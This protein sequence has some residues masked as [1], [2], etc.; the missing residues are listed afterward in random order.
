MNPK[1]LGQEKIG[2]LLAQQSAP[3]VIGMLVMS[4]YNFVDTI[5]IGRGVGTE[6]I[7]ALSIVF[8][9]QM[10]IGA[11]AMTMGIGAASVISRKLGKKKYGYVA[12]TFGTFQTVNILIA[13]IFAVLGLFLVK[14]LLVF[15]GA[16]PE[17]MTYASQ[18]FSILLIGIVFLCFNM[19]NNS[20]IRSVG[21]A[22]T[23]MI[24]MTVS[25]IIN[26]ILDPIMIFGLDMGMAGAA[27]A[28]VISRAVGSTIVLKYYFG[29]HNLIKTKISDYKI[30]FARFKEIFLVGVPS[31]ARQVAASGVVILINN[32]LGIYGG[33]LAIAAYGIINRALM[34]FFMPMF[35]VVQGM[36]PILGYNYGAG[37][38]TRV[39]E[40]TLLSI[41]VLTI[42]CIAIFAISMIFP[43][44]L[45]NLFSTDQELLKMAIPA[46]RI[47]VMMFPLIGFQIVASGFYQAL[48]KVRPA[49][50]FAI[51]RQVL[52]LL[53]M[54]L[55]IPRIFGLNGVWYSFP[56][57]DFLAAVVI[58]FVFRRDLKRIK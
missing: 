5:F 38:K 23:A 41:K 35:G 49:F 44:L 55:I 14:P 16:T 8:P 57:A 36:Q 17:I 50:W 51:M 2:K 22:K 34:V 24:V 13:V 1:H 19:G 32:L 12:K 26:I 52:I 27:R 56:L 47:I 42:F 7:A 54:L 30:R 31:L 33:S 39:K 40:V 25:A 20:V 4:L 29:K 46:M 21:H 45:L 6:G 3:A 53:P 10:I 11:F 15:F 18:Y 58:F 9:I 43:G 37:F 48:G 28:T